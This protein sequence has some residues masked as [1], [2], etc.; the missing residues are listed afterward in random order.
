MFFAALFT[1][2]GVYNPSSKIITPSLSRSKDYNFTIDGSNSSY[3]SII[4]LFPKNLSECRKV[5]GGSLLISFL[6]VYK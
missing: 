2:T 5:G 6:N 1:Y 3:L 4:L